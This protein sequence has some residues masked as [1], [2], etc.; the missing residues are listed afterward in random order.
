MTAPLT[1]VFG[2]MSEFLESKITPIPE[3]KMTKR[4]AFVLD[5]IIVVAANKKPINLSGQ[6]L[7]FELCEDIFSPILS[8]TILI[9]DAQNLIKHG[10]IV[11]QE[12]IIINFAT[13]GSKLKRIKK[14]FRIYKI[15]NR[16]VTESGKV[17]RYK[18][19]F[20]SKEAINNSQTRCNYSFVDKT[21]DDM[22][23]E[24]FYNHFPNS[25]FS[26]GNVPTKGKHTFILPNRN[27]F[28]CISW[29]AKRAINA[30]NLS[31]CSYVFYEDVDGF[32]LNTI[33]NLIS[34]HPTK[35]NF[36]NYE[37]KIANARSE[38]DTFRDLFEN[39]QN[40][41]NVVY[42][43]KSFNKLDDI[44]KGMYSSSI[45]L[46]D[47]TT[48]KYSAN[49]YN[50]FKHF[51][52]LFPSDVKKNPVLA[53][54][55][56]ETSQDRVASSIHFYPKSSGNIGE[57]SLDEINESSFNYNN[58]QYENWVLNR[59]SLEQQMESNKIIITVPGD[60]IRKVGQVVNFS[61]PSPEPQNDYTTDTM[62]EYV[63]G[64]YLITSVKHI[65]NRQDY[66][67]ILELSRNFLPTS[68]PT[69]SKL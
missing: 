69:S 49:T 45:L 53:H 46:Y 29:L 61:F 8:G 37:Y 43:E 52:S 60:S 66:R 12:E 2:G 62:D 22:I 24:V 56:E 58:D 41:E 59:E 64:N 27:P 50:Y 10:P 18:L 9:E 33:I 35:G 6:W 40:P 51:A 54:T 55:P 23:T 42:F 39:I 13:P 25:T 7:A 67:T 34:Q 65:V 17:Q 11:G 4:N 16:E 15:S 44:Q 32:K 30:N 1:N 5:D 31:D 14:R 26:M 28:Y 36:G 63:S 3:N 68:L 20:I 38:I 48:G 47:I 21:I 57:T 19:H